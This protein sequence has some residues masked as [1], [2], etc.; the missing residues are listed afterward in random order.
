[1][2][3]N[4]VRNIKKPVDDRLW[5]S[6][7]FPFAYLLQNKVMFQLKITLIYDK[8]HWAVNLYEASTC[9]NPEGG[10]SMVVQL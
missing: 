3:E 9:R 8:P 7:A 10:H 4:T 2:K 5:T 1:M 6:N